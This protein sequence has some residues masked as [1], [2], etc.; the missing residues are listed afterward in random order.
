MKT[1]T[2]M[3]CGCD[4]HDDLEICEEC[5]AMTLLMDD[6]L[7]GEEWPHIGASEE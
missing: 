6:A 5:H 3:W 1:G 2:C 4:L 7:W